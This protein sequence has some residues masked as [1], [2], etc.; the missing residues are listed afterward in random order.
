MTDWLIEADELHTYYG[1]SHVLHGVSLRVRRGEA[2]GLMGRNGMGKTTLLKSI[3]GLVRPRRGS[4]RLKGREVTAEAPHR[5]ARAGIAYVPEGRGIFR[6]MCGTYARL[7]EEIDRAGT[8]VFTRRVRV[9]RWRKGA[10]VLSGWA[11]KWGWL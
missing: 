3:L 10:I 6:V 5:I 9:P 11:A 8:G 4:V 2:L 1:S 7:L